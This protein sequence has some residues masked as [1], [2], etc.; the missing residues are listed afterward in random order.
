MGHADS[1]HG[2]WGAAGGA[3]AGQSPS[4]LVSV[5]MPSLNQAGF[6]ESAIRSLF[7]QSLPGL[8]LIVADG[9]SSDGT[10][11]RL[12]ALAEHYGERLHWRCEPDRGPAH[13]LNKAIA[14]ARGEILGWLNADDLYAPGALARALDFFEANPEAVMLYGEGEHIDAAGQRLGAYPTR[15]PEAGVDAFKDG[16]FICQPTVF[17][18]RAALADLGP[19]DETLATA[20]D[21]DLWI[22]FFKRYPG[23]IG[24]IPAV[25]A[26]S[27]LHPGCITNRQRRLVAL[28]AV[29]LLSRHLG[30]A[31]DHWLRTH[32]NEVLG[33][34][35]SGTGG[36]DL[37]AYVAALLE[38]AR[39]SLGEDRIRRLSTDL[40]ADARLR[41]AL[42][43]LSA[44]LYPD[45]WAPRVLTLRLRDLPAGCRALRL[46]CRHAWPT[47]AAL[48]LLLAPSWTAA[49][50]VRIRGL[51][52]FTLTIPLT[53][54]H[55]QG[56]HEIRI[57]ASRVLVPSRSE[58]GN[59]DHRELAFIVCGIDLVSI[60]EP[61]IRKGYGR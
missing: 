40:D 37:R 6:I 26:C 2:A 11:A 12:A 22:R 33:D 32:V 57:T 59:D 47:A 31:P 23:R 10:P 21:F 13:A 7:E 15:P 53:D 45:G 44:D 35:P 55:R 46:D 20:F 3:S 24:Y 58:P 14:E 51:G 50:R 27:R 39:G 1:T 18:R 43:N 36:Q 52:P 28:E 19:L 17:M 34:H 16:C 9:G 8:E 49:W 56:A 30:S 54:I 4:P 61:S 5:V 25:Q 42:P 38:D 48:D 41:L 60:T 29:R